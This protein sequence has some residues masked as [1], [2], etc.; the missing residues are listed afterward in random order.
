MSAGS[1]LLAWSGEKMSKH[2]NM[3]LTKVLSAC[4]MVVLVNLI[5]IRIDD[6]KNHA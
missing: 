3:M 4:F 1:G 6:N 2:V 5:V